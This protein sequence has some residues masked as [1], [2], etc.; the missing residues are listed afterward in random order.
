MRKQLINGGVEKV[1]KPSYFSVVKKRINSTFATE[2]LAASAANAASVAAANSNSGGSCVSG[3]EAAAN[4]SD[5]FEPYIQKLPTT[6][7]L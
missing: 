2:K 5:P 3:G 7:F 4:K 6:K 1:Y